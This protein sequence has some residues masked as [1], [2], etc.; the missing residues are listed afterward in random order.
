[1]KSWIEGHTAV[2]I[3]VAVAIGAAAS[4]IS[5]TILSNET[6]TNHRQSRQIQAEQQKA[7]HNQRHLAVVSCL[8]ETK[9]R[10]QARKRALNQ[11]DLLAGQIIDP[12][13]PPFLQAI[14]RADL[15]RMVIYPVPNCS[16]LRAQLRRN[17]PVSA[18]A[19]GLGRGR[20]ISV[21]GILRHRF[22]QVSASSPPP[23]VGSGGAFEA[24]LS[25]SSRP[26]PRQRGG[27]ESQR[28][29]SLLPSSGHRHA[30][31]PPCL[32]IP[33]LIPVPSVCPQPRVFLRYG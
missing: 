25:P 9:W 1:M 26:E 31:P 32:P 18:T 30:Q 22:K 13:T 29:G 7:A 17:T 14:Y 8:A 23:S 28:G 5:L 11:A 21:G 6:Q 19:I 15:H 24:G 4:A 33:G 16:L 10:M 12:R 27:G 2:L 3:L 20:H